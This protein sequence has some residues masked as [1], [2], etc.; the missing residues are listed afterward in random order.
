MVP[1]EGPTT[2]AAA[3]V[4]GVDTASLLFLGAWVMQLIMWHYAFISGLV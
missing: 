3:T 2:A 1:V 4:L